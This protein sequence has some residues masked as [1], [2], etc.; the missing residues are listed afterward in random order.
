MK[1]PPPLPAAIKHQIFHGQAAGGI[2]L[3]VGKIL[4]ER[5]NDAHQKAEAWLQSQPGIEIITIT[6]GSATY[7]DVSAAFFI[8]VWYRDKS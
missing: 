2:R 3:D 8:T 6:S 7:G 5:I 1:T 4:I